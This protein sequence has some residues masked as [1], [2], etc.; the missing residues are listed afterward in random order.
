MVVKRALLVFLAIIATG[1]LFAKLSDFRAYYHP[2]VSNFV[3]VRKVYS[4]DIFNL[5]HWYP[6]H[7]LPGPV[8]EH[9]QNHEI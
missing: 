2:M 3:Y 9:P 5:G 8:G 6:Y 7:L 1:V 4:G